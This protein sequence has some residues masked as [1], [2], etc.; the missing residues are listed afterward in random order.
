MAPLDLVSALVADQLR[1]HQDRLLNR[2]HKL[3]RFRDPERALETFDFDSNKKTRRSGAERDAALRFI[4]E[5]SAGDQFAG[6]RWSSQQASGAL[7]AAAPRRCD[8]SRK[9]S[10]LSVQAQP[11]SPSTLIA[12]DV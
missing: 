12:D 7:R 1:R 10:G 3:A 9:C 6:R 11:R 4:T 8:A 5:L 2:R